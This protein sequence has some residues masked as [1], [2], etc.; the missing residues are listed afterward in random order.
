MTKTDAVLNTPPVVIAGA[1][2][3]GYSLPDI[4]AFIT[5]VYTAVLIYFRMRKE[6]RLWREKMQDPL[7][8]DI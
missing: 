7:D 6:Y 5:I 1:T 3:F 4:A 2:I 8:S